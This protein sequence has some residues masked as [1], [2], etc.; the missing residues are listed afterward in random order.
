MCPCGQHE[1]APLENLEY[2]TKFPRQAGNDKPERSAAKHALEME[3]VC[4]PTPR[5]AFVHPAVNCAPC[6]HE[7][8]EPHFLIADDYLH[9][10]TFPILL[11]H[12]PLYLFFL[13][14][15]SL[16]AALFFPSYTVHYYPS[17]EANSCHPPIGSLVW[18]TCHPV[19]RHLRVP[20]MPP[21]SLP[22]Y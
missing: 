19:S 11:P 18:V 8:T 21:L 2:F 15:C 12:P 13:L 20:E 4:T 17:F 7:K 16:F 14:V 10:D 1:S 22:N 5:V 3:M 6:V 9:T